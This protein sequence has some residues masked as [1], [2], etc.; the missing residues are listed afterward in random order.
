MT[1]QFKNQLLNNTD[2]IRFSG[3]MSNIVVLIQI[4]GGVVLVAMLGYGFFLKQTGKVEESKS[5]IINSVLGFVG[6]G[7][8]S[9]I[10]FIIKTTFGIA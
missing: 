10:V 5:V 4:L 7:F 1:E 3:G 2:F 8:I 9:L 6:L